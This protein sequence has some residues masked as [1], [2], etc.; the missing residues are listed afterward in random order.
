MNYFCGSINPRGDWD[1][2]KFTKGIED[3]FLAHS[4]MNPGDLM[5]LFVGKQDSKI[6]SGIYAIIECTSDIF[7]VIEEGRKRNRINAKCLYNNGSSPF[8][9]RLETEKFVH[10]PIRVPVMIKKNLTELSNIIDKYLEYMDR[11]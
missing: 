5:V 8:L 4:K 7:I 11:R 3:D 2:F 6:E 1:I 9:N 10:L